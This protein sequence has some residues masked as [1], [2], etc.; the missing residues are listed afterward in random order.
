MLRPK[1]K[2]LKLKHGINAGAPRM[3]DGSA[4]GLGHESTSLTAPGRPVQRGRLAAGEASEF[5]LLF[6]IQD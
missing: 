3:A 4:A 1:S 2:S 6:R 5:Q